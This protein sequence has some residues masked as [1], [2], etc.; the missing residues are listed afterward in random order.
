M[1]VESYML[2][3]THGVSPSQHPCMSTSPH[4][5]PHTCPPILMC[6]STLEEAAAEF[7]R[8]EPRG[9]IVVLV[10]GYLPTAEEEKGDAD[11]SDVLRSLLEGGEPVSSA[12][13]ETMEAV[14]TRVGARRKDVYDLAL[15]MKRRMKAPAVVTEGSG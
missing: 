1:V 14:G 10:E 9:E 2:G 4:C 6:R 8:R 12:V 11:V 5:D 15:K 7:E 13:R 3:P